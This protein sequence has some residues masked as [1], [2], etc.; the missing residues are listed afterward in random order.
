[1]VAPQVSAV[2]LV[3]RPQAVGPKQLVEA[4]DVRGQV[5]KLGGF[6]EVG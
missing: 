4:E 1:M 2:H 5:R 6:G 3:C